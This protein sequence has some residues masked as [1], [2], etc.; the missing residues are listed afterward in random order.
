M[1]NRPKERVETKTKVATS[2]F[3][4]LDKG[5]VS[6][7]NLINSLHIHTKSQPNQSHPPYRMGIS[8]T[9]ESRCESYRISPETKA[10]L[11]LLRQSKG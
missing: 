8:I 9:L 10:Q 1:S 6:P 7:A 3:S 5:L 4:L 11:K 2:Y